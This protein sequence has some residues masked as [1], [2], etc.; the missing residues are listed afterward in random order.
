MNKSETSKIIAVLMAS[1]P[2]F[3]SNKTAT[4]IQATISIW[5]EM[6]KDY[7]Y[8]EVSIA[9]KA[10]ISQDKTGF[11][12][13]IG[14]VI[15]KILSFRNQENE[16]TEQEAWNYVSKA[17][18]N[19]GYHAT[20]EY[21]KLPEIIKQVVTPSQLYEWSQ[22]E[23]DSVQSVVAS[24]FMRS[25]K[26]KVA[27]NKEYQALPNEVKQLISGMSNRLS[28]ASGGSNDKKQH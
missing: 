14:Q 22:M 5:D 2:N 12:P 15:N 13:S 6:L 18:K 8:Q 23:T 17:I 27:K 7:N 19:S 11:A 16:L 25:Y 1:F 28:I 21:E 10:C 9:I 24:N 26:V 4:D 3:L 20:E